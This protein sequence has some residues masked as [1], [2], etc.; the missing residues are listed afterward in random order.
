MEG[1]LQEKGWG[2]RPI[3]KRKQKRGGKKCQGFYYADCFFFSWGMGKVP[4]TD[5]VT[6]PHWC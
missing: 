2:K 4:V 3:V 1:F 6:A 5:Y